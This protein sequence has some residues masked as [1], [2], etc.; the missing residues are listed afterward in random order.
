[1]EQ[2][3]C[4]NCKS[5]NVKVLVVEIWQKDRTFVM[6]DGQL[7]EDQKEVPYFKEESCDSRVISCTVCKR[8]F[9]TSHKDVDQLIDELYEVTDSGS[10]KLCEL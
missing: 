5:E 3:Y 1:M 2:V 7:V 4:P 6:K 8:D 9:S 10:V